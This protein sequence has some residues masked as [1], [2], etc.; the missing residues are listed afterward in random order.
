MKEPTCDLS[1]PLISFELLSS[2]LL[3]QNSL[4]W[5]LSTEIEDENDQII[6]SIYYKQMEST[7]FK[8]LHHRYEQ[9]YGKRNKQLY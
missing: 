1:L 3:E 4:N 5:Y 7:T 9:E 8:H 2:L 6:R